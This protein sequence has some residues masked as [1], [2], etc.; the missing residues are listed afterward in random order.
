[1]IN[2]VSLLPVQNNY[3]YTKRS[4]T[5][6]NLSLGLRTTKGQ[7]RLHIHAVWS[8]PLLYAYWKVSYQNM[9]QVKFQFSS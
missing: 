9:L 8:G 3:I 2:K 1:M 6:E 7:T 5:R 4:S